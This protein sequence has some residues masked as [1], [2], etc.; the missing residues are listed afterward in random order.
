MHFW[1]QLQTRCV[2]TFFKMTNKSNL[3]FCSFHHSA[4]CTGVCV[5][6]GSRPSATTPSC[7]SLLPHEA[8]VIACV[9]LKPCSVFRLFYIWQ[10]RTIP[11]CFYTK[12]SFLKAS[13][14]TTLGS[15]ISWERNSGKFCFIPL[16]TL[17]RFNCIKLI[18]CLCNIVIL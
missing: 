18:E 5:W 3:H 11:V 7:G 1:F 16:K 13:Q 17:V 15:P 9:H 4:S 8:S 12:L 10:L 14:C 2:K 6:L